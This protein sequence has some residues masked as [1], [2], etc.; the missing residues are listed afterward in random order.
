MGSLDDVCVVSQPISSG[1]E[2]HV[3]AL[4]EI[5][6][7]LTT[8]SLVTANVPTDSA[9]R[10]EYEV[11]D[12]AA[13][14][15]GRSILTAAVRFVYNQ[16]RMAFEL[17]RREEQIVL[18]FG[19]TSYLLPILAATLSGKTVVLEPRGD[20]P[21]TLRLNWE[22]RI[23]KPIARALAGSV[24]LLETV[25]YRLSDAI[26]TYTPSMAEQLGLDRYGHKLHPYGARYVDTDRF[27]P[28]VPYEERDRVVGFL[29]RLDE[30]KGIRKLAAVAKQLPDDVTF[31]FAG[32]GELRGWL[33]EELSAEIESGSV[34]V[35]GWVDHGD[36]P[37]V[38]SRFRLLV[39]LSEQTEG[40][41]TVILESMACGTPVY[42]P[43]VSGIPDV[44]RDGE[45]GIRMETR[46]PS[47]VAAEIVALLDG[48]GS[49]AMSANG[50]GAI[51][52]T[53]SF[54]AAIERYRSIVTDL[55][56]DEEVPTDGS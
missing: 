22:R 30:E 29:G 20:V 54:E 31:V 56:T 34:E 45:T 33:E 53:Y 27:Y 1:S 16:F 44:V 25:A 17:R 23:P 2:P 51:E 7:E 11:V 46:D 14:G 4:L 15:T 18:F 3:L 52:L 8:V 6:G 39:L 35:L 49:K 9:I 41:P 47:A 32:D 40:L 5:L 26:I 21:L 13:S 37:E 28:R 19:T 12:I 43:P 55:T 24:G 36:V 48:E 50:R 10:D 42:A 38:L